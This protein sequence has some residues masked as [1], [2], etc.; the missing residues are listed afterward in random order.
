MMI[1]SRLSL[2]L[3][4]FTLALVAT[5]CA[6]NGAQTTEVWPTMSALPESAPAELSDKSASSEEESAYL[7]RAEDGFIYAIGVEEGIEV[8]QEFFGRYAGEWP[9]E[10]LPRPTLLTG[11]LVKRYADGIGLVHLSYQ[12]E[13]SEIDGLM[14]D[15]VTEPHKPQAPSA[16]D[17]SLD[18][19]TLGKA[20][21]Y[22]ES[23]GEEG[24]RELTLGLGDDHGV[25][26]GDFYALL[27]Q[28]DPSAARDDQARALQ[29]Q[30]SR[31]ISGVCMVQKVK[32]STS[33]C[34]R[35]TAS[36]DL[37]RLPQPQE[38][39]QALFLEHT[40]GAAP[41]PGVIQIAQIEGAEPAVQE[42][43]KQAMSDFLSSVTEPHTTVASL[44]KTF[45]AT[46]PEFYKFTEEIEPLDSAQMVVGAS[47]HEVDGE[48]H[49]FAN[50]S[51]V[52]SASGPGMVAAPPRHGV[53]LGPLSALNEATLKNFAATVWAGMLVYR[54]QTSEALI[55]LHQMLTSP[56]LVGP[57][58]WHA[59]DQYAMR[60]GALGHLRES[61]WL[62]LQ[63]EALGA[64]ADDEEHRLNALGTR[65]RLYDFLEFP[66]SAIS[67]AKSYLDA[68]QDD[69]PESTWRSA[70][71]MYAEMLMKAE[72]VDEALAELKKLEEVCPDGCD[73]ELNNYT[74][75]LFW[76]VPTDKN[77]IREELLKKLVD[78]L[79]E[80]DTAQV[81]ALRMYQGLM[82]MRQE[83][84]TQSLIAF[85]EAERL[86]TKLHNLS[87]QARALSFAFMAEL[88]R[89][90]PQAAYE[91][92]LKAQKLHMKINDFSGSADL[93]QRM[94]V[95]YANP[96]FMENPGPF[97]G[98]ARQVLSG[99]V[100]AAVAMGDLNQTGEALMA[101]GSF[102]LKLGADAQALETLGQ[103][104]A[105]GVASAR[106]DIAALSHLYSALIAQ[107]QGDASGFRRQIA[108]AQ[109]MAKLSKDPAIIEAIDEMLN[110]QEAPEIPTQLL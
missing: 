34:M 71:G 46:S 93:F 35:W 43:L 27:T 106:F 30:L 105:V 76:S 32:E 83:D 66:D 49:L 17:K 50:Y 67:A 8:G 51:G 42:Q 38:G 21:G 84:F 36:S 110:P 26:D 96:E 52:G 87:G 18:H 12:V 2:I 11:R 78:G 73:G 24:S 64:R 103:A 15:W 70:L 89:S 45:D 55:Q 31:R 7:M 91:K 100:E 41:R 28:P 97:L 102:Q 29:Q 74:A 109:L 33:T 3:A 69:K 90:E 23:L 56:E 98:A 59:R 79:D 62:V 99:A 9:L 5:A 19:L 82:S 44:D 4:S 40:F 37:G 108:Q 57:L 13:D 54:G 68:N 85:L 63:D 101:L 88:G 10:D 60:W 61:L 14:V 48:A 92:A 86:Y 81:A 80:E 53:D 72:Q 22:I 39:Q 65:V 1:S 95:L 25:R 58:R 20:I 94:G 77:E 107:K 6:T 16:E 104:A 75:A 47:V